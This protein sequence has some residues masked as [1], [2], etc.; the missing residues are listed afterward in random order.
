MD[1]QFPIDIILQETDPELVKM[2]LDL[3]WI[4]KVGKD[5]VA[6]FEQNPNRSELWHVKD[7][8]NSSK[9]YFTEVGNGVIDFKKIF[10]AQ[11]ISGMKHFFVEQD[12]SDDPMKSAEVSFKNLT[13]KILA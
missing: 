7:M 8:D 2:E 12:Q 1:G 11:K 3:Y 10:D 6:F 9:Q 5:P 4:S 13:E